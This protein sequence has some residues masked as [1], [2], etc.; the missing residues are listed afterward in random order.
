MWGRSRTMR[1]VVGVD[2]W[3]RGWVAISL[4]NGRFAGA[5]VF[6]RFED[7]LAAHGHADAIG[8]DIPIGIPVSGPRPADVEAKRRLGRG[9]SSVFPTPPR[10]VLESPDHA[11]ATALHVQLAGHGLSQQSFALRPK[12]LEVDALVTASD[13]V[14]EVHPEVTFIEL[15]G[16]RLSASKKTWAG[17]MR[18]MA[19]LSE[20][21]IDLPVDLGAASVVPVDDVLDAAAVA[22]SAD[23][24]ARGEA[25]SLP[26]DPPRDQRGRE[27]A[28][29][30]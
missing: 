14:I 20:A 3:R 9:G 19:L 7:L 8:V 2:G 21:G 29:W 10:T 25:L 1:L 6:A 15:A 12:I 18:R 11:S 4:R 17:V 13:P 26:A 23:R 28:V 27:V 5:E 24:Y 30:Y 16:E 22:W